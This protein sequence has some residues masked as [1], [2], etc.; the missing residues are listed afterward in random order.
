[1]DASAQF[2]LRVCSEEL[3]DG[4]DQVCQ[5]SPGSSSASPI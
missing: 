4:G 3:L 2:F 1:M 5:I